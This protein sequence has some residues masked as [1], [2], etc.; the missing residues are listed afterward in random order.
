MHLK[1]PQN[2]TLNG[3]LP[4]KTINF[5]SQYK[6][7]THSRVTVMNQQESNITGGIEFYQDYDGH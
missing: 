5:I 1:T 4:Q 7:L 6:D 2:E 3:G